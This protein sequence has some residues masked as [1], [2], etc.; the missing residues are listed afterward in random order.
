M[1]QIR[2]P[3][4]LI[5][6]LAIGIPARFLTLAFTSCKGHLKLFRAGLA[7]TR[8]HPIKASLVVMAVAVEIGNQNA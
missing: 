4:E 2:V 7:E 6:N 8:C 1:L 3:V 5:G